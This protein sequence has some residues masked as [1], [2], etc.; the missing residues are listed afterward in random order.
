MLFCPL[1]AVRFAG[2]WC[3]WNHSTRKNPVADACIERLHPVLLIEDSRCP[4]KWLSPT[5]LLG[6]P[7]GQRLV[8][9]LRSHVERSA[10]RHRIGASV[11]ALS[12]ECPRHDRG[13]VQAGVVGSSEAQRGR[14]TGWKTDRTSARV[15]GDT[16]IGWCPGI[17]RPLTC[18]IS[19]RSS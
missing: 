15:S 4:S 12:A 8:N 10:L 2:C 7:T 14:A 1:S 18:M 9:L 5:A 11:Y 13:L 6:S 17:S 3:L 16:R 19:T